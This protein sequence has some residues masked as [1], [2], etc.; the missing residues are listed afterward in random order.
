[1][2]LVGLVA[3][4]VAFVGMASIHAF[5]QPPFAPPDETAHIGYAHDVA[6]FRLPE[7]DRAA[8]FVIPLARAKILAGQ[9]PFLDRLESLCDGRSPSIG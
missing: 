9:R 4:V 7:I 2:E 5:Q 1:M 3:V 6:D 8:W